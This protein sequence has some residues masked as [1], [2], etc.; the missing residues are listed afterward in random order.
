MSRFVFQGRRI[1]LWPSFFRS[2]NEKLGEAQILEIGL[3]I[4][5]VR[6]PQAIKQIQAE[7]LGESEKEQVP[8]MCSVTCVSKPG[9]R[10]YI[11][12]FE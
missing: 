4:C 2:E 5:L 11:R 6:V 10:T 1:D 7:M 8:M 9:R 12:T 3:S